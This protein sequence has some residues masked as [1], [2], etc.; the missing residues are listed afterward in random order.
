MVDVQTETII[1]C[2]RD[3][4]SQYTANPD[5]APEW[6]INI[7]KVEWK[8][9]KPLRLG[10]RIAFKA[11]FLG[12]ELAYIYEVVEYQPEEKM[13]MRTVNGPFPME[14]T[15]EW[16]SV[17]PN[18][19]LMKLRN[20]GEP[21]GFSKLFAPFMSSAMRKANMKDLRKAKTIIESNNP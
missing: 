4:V 2:S 5:H 3:K 21:R 17:S 20:R 1:R 16:I 15:Y 13:V 7:K 6:Y 9:P 18:E 8:T 11:Q 10:S 12:R 19:T 14:T